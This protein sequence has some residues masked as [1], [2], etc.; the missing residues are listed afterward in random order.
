[1]KKRKGELAQAV[2][3]LA[4]E[5]LDKRLDTGSI[6]LNLLGFIPGVSS[7]AQIMAVVHSGRTLRKIV[8]F[9]ELV[10]SDLNELGISVT[11]AMQK[12]EVEA[13][14]RRCISD[15]PLE[16][17][18]EKLEAYRRFLSAAAASGE[19]AD[20]LEFILAKVER[21]CNVEI[22]VLA[23]LTSLGDEIRQN[24]SDKLY[25]TK[26]KELQRMLD[27]PKRKARLG[28]K[29]LDSPDLSIPALLEKRLGVGLAEAEQTIVS[30]EVGGLLL[31]NASKKGKPSMVDMYVLEHY[32][33]IPKYISPIAWN[34][35][36]LALTP[37]EAS[38]MA[39]KKSR[40][41][42]R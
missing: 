12:E 16:Q 25:E 30:L 4:D 28:I 19:P 36:A 8:R 5:K 27:Y 17:G 13:L 33:L 26:G 40:H 34:I 14:F 20:N 7:G 38:V 31:T 15:I 2:A 1:M 42:G 24:E 11:E 10:E 3:Q 22:R 9:A 37:R 6:L 39:R 21:L 23:V 18:E 32:W 35:H 29:D 41:N